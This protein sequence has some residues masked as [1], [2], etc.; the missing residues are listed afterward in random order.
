MTTLEFVQRSLG[1]SYNYYQ[2]N[3][4]SVIIRDQQHHFE[5]CVPANYSGPLN[6]AIYF[7]GN[8]GNYISAPSAGGYDPN[9]NASTQH[10]TTQE[11]FIDAIVS[12]NPNTVAVVSG[13]SYNGPKVT[14]LTEELNGI[15]STLNL[16][17]QRTT[18]TGFSD[19]GSNAIFYAAQNQVDDILLFDAFSFNNIDGS[20]FRQIADNGSRLVLV[21]GY[22][23][24]FG[25]YGFFNKRLQTAFDN[26]V[27]CYYIYTHNAAHCRVMQE[28]LYYNNLLPF[29]WGNNE[30]TDLRNSRYVCYMYDEETGQFETVDPLTLQENLNNFIPNIDRFYKNDEG[31]LVKLEGLEAASRFESLKNLDQLTIDGVVSSNMQFVLDCMNELRSQISSCGFLDGSMSVVSASAEGI[32]G[33]ISAYLN[34]YYNLVGEL[35]ESMRKESEAVVNAGIRIDNIDTQLEDESEDLISPETS[36]KP[37]LSPDERPEPFTSEDQRQ[38][39]I[40]MRQD[41]AFQRLDTLGNYLSENVQPGDSELL[42]RVPRYD[43]TGNVIGYE[44]GT[45]TFTNG[46]DSTDST[47]TLRTSDGLTTLGQNDELLQEVRVIPRVDDSQPV[48]PT[49]EPV[50]EPTP[51][52]VPEPTPEPVPEPTPEPV[53]PT[54]IEPTPITPTPVEPIKP[55]PVEPEIITPIEPEIV[56]PIEP[57]VPVQDDYSELINDTNNRMRDIKVLDDLSNIEVNTETNANN[58]ILKTIGIGAAVGG[59]IGA[60]AYAINNQM[61]KKDYDYEYEE[62]K[63]SKDKEDQKDA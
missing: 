37:P 36:S 60:S 2:R 12:N 40:R 23:N 18:V 14:E 25:K 39:Q 13:F 31:F 5:V 48:V 54:P 19:G 63:K 29:V 15:M 59:A 16:N 28:G 6:Q 45:I 49:P 17:V 33:C 32:P 20:Y 1:D 9:R 57:E 62:K 58:D 41:E 24:Q 10:F 47:I 7:P 34:K 61:K 22:T 56:T 3:D 30:L 43:E 11:D 52:P 53:I 55:Q 51:E 46:R 21:G 50:P 44:T 38:E 42:V 4:G 8:D 27:E 26:G 35:M